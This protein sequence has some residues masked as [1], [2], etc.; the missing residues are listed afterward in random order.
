MIES[1]NEIDL[2]YGVILENYLGLDYV[3]GRL[4]IVKEVLEGMRIYLMVV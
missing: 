3:L 1:L 4:K 2:F